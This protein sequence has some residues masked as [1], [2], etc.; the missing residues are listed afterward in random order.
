[1]KYGLT[2]D[3][4][5]QMTDVFK[6]F[7]EIKTVIIFGSRAKGVHKKTSDID[8]ALKGNMNLNIVSKIRYLLDE[9][10][11]LP[12]F[13][14]VINYH[15]IKTPSFKQHIDTYGEILYQL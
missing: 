1:M 10:T 15:T 9:T 14:D 7:K 3:E 8:I 2:N 4:I 6:R 5:K 13:F 12:Y 11:Q